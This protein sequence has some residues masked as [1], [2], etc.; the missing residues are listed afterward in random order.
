MCLSA[1]AWSGFDNFYYF[2]SYEDTR[3]EF[4]IP[5]DLAMLDE[6]FRCPDGRYSSI[7]AY[8]RSYYIHDLIEQASA[9]E[10]RTWNEQVAELRSAYAL[11]SRQYQDTK[12]ETDIP[13]A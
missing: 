2:F 3:D 7:N 8:W 1:V 4:E 5:H 10:R 6:L 13:L 11:L 9:G 12:R